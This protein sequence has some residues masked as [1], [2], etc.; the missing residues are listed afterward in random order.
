MI[1]NDLDVYALAPNFFLPKS[2]TKGMN[3][4]AP[5]NHFSSFSPRG[6]TFK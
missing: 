4:S 5:L 1:V 3:L 6:G 2:N